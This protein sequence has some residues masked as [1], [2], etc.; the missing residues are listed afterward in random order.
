LPSIGGYGGERT[1]FGALEIRGRI[2]RV[3]WDPVARD[4]S[5]VAAFL[6]VYVALE[7]LSFIHEYKGVP[8]TPWNP[9]L[10]VLFAPMVLFGAKFG[11]VLCLG[12]LLVEFGI[13]ESRLP[14]FAIVG[15]AVI[16]S[17]AYGS[18]AMTAR[19]Y[20]RLD[21]GLASLR[22]VFVLLGA[23]L[24][25]A[26]VVAG[27]LSLLLVATGPLE[28]TDVVGAAIPLLVGDIIGVSVVT[29]LML[30]FVLQRRGWALDR[31][32]AF[33][34]EGAG[35][36]LVIALA[37]WVIV[38]G[39]GVNEFKYV[40]LLFLPVVVAAARYGMDG[41]CLVLVATQLA[42]VAVL[43]S[44]GY[45]ADAFTDFQTVM[46]VLTV[47]GLVV[48]V[49]VSERQRADQAYRA[50]SDRL[51]EKEA[52]A[53]QAGRFHLLSGM[54]SALAHEINQPMA[55]ARA[56]ARSAQELL[57]APRGDLPRAEANLRTAIM[58]IDHAGDIVRRMR[59]FLRRGQ[60]RYSTT[61]IRGLLEDALALVRP[62]AAARAIV[63]ELDVDDDLPVVHADRVQLQQVALNL[64][65]N[66]LDSI[67]QSGRAG[68]RIRV[69]ARRLDEPPQIEVT[70]ADDGPGIEPEVAGRLFTPLTTSKKDGLGLGLAICAAILEAHGGRVWLHSGRAGATE[71]R[72]TLPYERPPTC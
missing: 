69:V 2:A 1:G 56:L 17:L 70:V 33:A 52:E 16:Y 7:W 21:A 6:A 11:L 23:A 62:A 36:V 32:R 14:W 42:L 4:W 29:P 10:G 51:K 37:L 8:I 26:G 68:G 19:R 67:A 44:Q 38:G 46:F 71:F 63:I 5:R 59:D 31:P 18:L 54:T 58:H 57:R 64:V 50:A 9:G 30:R 24:A 53:A 3:R 13:V 34:L 22:D 41:A 45:D 47:T 28:P 55:A 43:Q 49:V 72:F 27:L 48:G 39:E 60:P 15:I 40:Y 61:E 65:Q 35:Y 12:V 25:G 20:F 66:G